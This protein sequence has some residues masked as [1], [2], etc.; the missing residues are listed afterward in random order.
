MVAMALSEPQPPP[1]RMETPPDTSVVRHPFV[2][3]PLSNFQSRGLL[4]VA[5]APWRIARTKKTVAPSHLQL[6]AAAGYP[7]AFP[8]SDWLGVAPLQFL[9]APL[10]RLV[11]PPL[12][13]PSTRF[14]LSAMQVQPAVAFPRL[15]G[16]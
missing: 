12:L 14:V 1:P 9:A 4:F 7:Q 15:W 13:Q 6:Q 16:A 11:I 2:L 10:D 3:T 5:V 8:S